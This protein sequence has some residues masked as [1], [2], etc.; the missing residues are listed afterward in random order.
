MVLECEQ[1]GALVDARVLET[2]RAESPV[3]D[4]YLFTFAACPKCSGPFLAIQEWDPFGEPETPTRI[5]PPTSHAASSSLPAEIRPSL[6]EA[7]TCYRAKAFTASAVMCRK[8]LEAICRV[9]KVQERTLAASLKKLRD[10]GVI[11]A[12]LYEW[13][14]ALR[15]F[16][17]DAAH[18]VDVTI[19]GPD[20]RD[21]L[22]FTRALVE[23]VFTFRERFDAFKKRRAANAT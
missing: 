19:S 18:D 1:C 7:V 15:L 9:H 11:D 16:G 6:E 17:N 3:G 23:Y 8:T 20:A 4:E 22:D 2:H 12:R 13:A 5:Y 21:I 10:D 14:D